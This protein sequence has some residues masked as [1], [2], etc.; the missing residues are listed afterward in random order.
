MNIIF[1]PQLH[2]LNESLGSSTSLFCKLF[3]WD[4]NVRLISE[5]WP[6]VLCICAKCVGFILWACSEIPCV[7]QTLFLPVGVALTDSLLG[8]FFSF[9]RWQTV[10]LGSRHAT[11]HWTQGC[12][13]AAVKGWWKRRD[14]GG[15]FFVSIRRHLLFNIDVEVFPLKD[16][17]QICFSAIMKV[18]YK[19]II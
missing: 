7:M 6:I 16:R 9:I 11:L 13:N 12:G 2:F 19:N 1:S 5:S 10:V 15:I 17:L 3:Y 18:K 8:F 14:N 4:Y